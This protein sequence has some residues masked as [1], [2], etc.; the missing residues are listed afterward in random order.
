MNSIVIFA[1]NYSDGVYGK[2]NG[3]VSA[4]G[5]SAYQAVEKPGWLTSNPLEYRL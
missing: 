4:I 3:I 1:V 5:G 2:V